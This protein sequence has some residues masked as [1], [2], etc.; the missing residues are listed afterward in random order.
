MEQ[1]VVIEQSL[2]GVVGS[3]VVDDESRCLFADNDDVSRCLAML[4]H[5]IIAGVYLQ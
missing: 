5:M 3:H 2:G 4:C 1:H